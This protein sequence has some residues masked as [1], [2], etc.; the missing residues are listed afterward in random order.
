MKKITKVDYELVPG[1]IRHKLGDLQIWTEAV[2]PLG[3]D[4]IP[5]WIEISV[6]RY[7]DYAGQ[8][9]NTIAKK[10]RYP[11]PAKAT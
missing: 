4:G 2:G 3:D 10:L 6:F 11:R 1:G 5:E 7:Q 9:G 8:R